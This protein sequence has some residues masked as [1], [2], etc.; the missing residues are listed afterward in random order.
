MVVNT[1]NNEEVH[2]KEAQASTIEN[3]ISQSLRIGVSI[4]ALVI[5]IG[6]ALLLFTGQTGYAGPFFP[7]K[8]GEILKGLMQ[9]KP[10]AVIDVG[11]ILLILT[12]VFRVA[13]SVVVFWREKDYTYVI[14]NLLVLLMLAVGFLVGKAG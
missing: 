8:M 3:L 2:I 14:I 10:Y 7:V 12:P 4:S 5:A 6:F 11:L 1:V 13:A 9:L